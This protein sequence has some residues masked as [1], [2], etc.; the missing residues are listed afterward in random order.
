[1]DDANNDAEIKSTEE[2]LNDFEA[3]NSKREALA[4]DF[5]GK[6]SVVKT[7]VI[8][9]MDIK[10][11]YPSINPR[12]VAII[13]RIMWN[14][15]NVKV[16]NIDIKKLCKYIGK[17]IEKEK[18]ERLN[19]QEVVFTKKSIK[20]VKKKNKKIPEEEL[21]QSPKRLPSQ[22]E[23][24]TMVGLIIE[25]V[26]LLCMQNHLYQ[27]HGDIHLQK[28]TGA[29]G[30]DITGLAADIYMLWWDMRYQDKL[31]DLNINLD[32]Y[33]RFKDDLN[34]ISN[35]LPLGARYCQRNK[36][37]QYVTPTFREIYQNE[38]EKEIF[39]SKDIEKNTLYVLHQIANDVDSM[40]KFTFDHPSNHEDKKMPV[41][42]LKVHINDEGFI[43]HE[44][45][46]KPTK[47]PTV[48]LPSSAL[49]WNVKRTV[50]T[51]EALRRIRNTSQRLG[52]EA[53]NSALSQYMLKLK[54]AGYSPKFRAEI[55]KSA[56]H[57]FEIQLEN[58]KNG[59]RP[60]YRDKARI[61]SDKKEKGVLKYNWWNKNYKEA[62]HT[63]KYDTIVF[64]PPTPGSKL[65]KM[66]QRREAEINTA[67]DTRIKV[68]E[69]GGTKL[70]H[71][72]TT[73]NPFPPAPC[74]RKLCPVCKQTLFTEPVDLKWGAPPCS[75]TGVTY[76][77]E[78]LTCKE[79]GSNARYEGETGRPLINRATEHL[80]GL[81]NSNPTNPMVKHQQTQHRGDQK[82]V[83]FKINIQ[84][85]FPDPLTRQAREGVR[86]SNPADSALIFN[87]KSEFNHPK[88]ARIRIAS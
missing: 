56:K 44:F 61:I 28:N 82:K 20:P 39:E 75:S 17:E 8:G 81:K 72:I 43:I 16:K 13:A 45:Y 29:T 36:E 63:S 35:P 18:I 88:I 10:S 23:V 40:I 79:G 68:V 21:W 85:K 65:A 62:R 6:V 67:S 12:K 84:Q 4:K 86:I 30:L 14:K 19:L 1:M 46:E 5:Q 70:K 26:V 25:N 32:V 59:T 38:E 71:I 47:N 22:Q 50:F 83:R 42:D 48:I 76:N 69:K 52:C 78:C 31:R 73:R 58:A 27:F 15:S 24:K 54:D 77:Y 9:S 74:H 87:S 41:L 60:L 2:L 49:N 33:K 66:M 55:V 64:V 11:F 7:K 34:I 57:A 53:A 80:R 37:I 51:Q 3:Y